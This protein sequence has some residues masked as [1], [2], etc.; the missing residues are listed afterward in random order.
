VDSEGLGRVVHSSPDILTAA[1]AGRAAQAK[2][3]CRTFS[4]CTTAPRNGLP[5]GCYPLD[6]YYKTS[7]LHAKLKEA[8]AKRRG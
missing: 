1:A 5:S 2:K 4:D 7:E 8:K 6:E 3:I